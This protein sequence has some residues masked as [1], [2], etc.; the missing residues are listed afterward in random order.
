MFSASRFIS[1][2]DNLFQ[3]LTYNEVTFKYQRMKKMSVDKAGKVQLEPEYDRAREIRAFDET[4][5][6]VKGLVDAGISEPLTGET[7]F[8]ATWLL[9][10]LTRKSCLN[11][12][13]I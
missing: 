11:H 10:L 4:K 5:A 13:G 2:S 8:V 1:Y 9:I 7:L 12:S 6:G 3:N